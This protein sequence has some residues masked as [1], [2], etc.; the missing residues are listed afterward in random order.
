[1]T[2]GNRWSLWPSTSQNFL[3][4]F[5][6]KI[7]YCENI[8]CF[9]VHFSTRFLPPC[10]SPDLMHACWPADYPKNFTGLCFGSTSLS[11]WCSLWLRCIPSP[12]AEPVCW[13]LRCCQPGVCRRRKEDKMKLSITHGSDQR[14]FA[15]FSKSFV[16]WFWKDTRQWAEEQGG[17]RVTTFVKNV[18]NLIPPLWTLKP[19]IYHLLKWLEGI[20]FLFITAFWKKLL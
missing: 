10:I 6:Y 14:F 2:L 13:L 7:S 4:D 17:N 5:I 18:I 15:T 20:F 11:S 8:Y 12:P 19:R 3:P 1:M 9:S 16:T